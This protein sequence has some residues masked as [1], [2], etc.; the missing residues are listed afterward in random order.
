MNCSFTNC[1]APL[2]DRMHVM[3]DQ[4]KFYAVSVVLSTIDQL[5]AGG[6]G[7]TNRACATNCGQ[8]LYRGKS[9]LCHCHA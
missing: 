6:S 9:R 7:E 3:E 2:V 4:G 8:H 1:P 5:I